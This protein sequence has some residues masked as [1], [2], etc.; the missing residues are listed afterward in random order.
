LSTRD[1]N[2]S[3]LGLQGTCFTKDNPSYGVRL[4][5]NICSSY[6]KAKNEN[7][8]NGPKADKFSYQEPFGPFQDSKGTD[9]FPHFD[10]KSPS[11]LFQSNNNDCG[12]AAIANSMAF[13]IHNKDKWFIKSN[14]ST[15]GKSED[16][17]YLLNDTQ[18]GL[19][20]FWKKLTKDAR[21]T[22]YGPS[23]DSKSIF[24]LMRKEYL[25]V[26]DQIAEDISSEST[27]NRLL[28]DQVKQQ[29]IANATIPD[30]HKAASA[31]T[32][33]EDEDDNAAIR[34]DEEK[35]LASA[36][37]ASFYVQPSSTRQDEQDAATAM[38]SLVQTPTMF[39]VSDGS[40][41]VKASPTEEKQHPV[42]Q[43]SRATFCR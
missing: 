34:Q 40:E 5:L 35:Q 9:E 36:L 28:Y 8:G 37:A 10:Y 26:V 25:E 31:A 43:R 30:Q 27:S 38:A 4:F 41:D 1:N 2:D 23:F 12:L 18:Y 39:H 11:I 29:T 22:R 19:K 13:I 15:G 14:M 24:K 3:G 17:R 16:V 32:M 20:P 21:R 7:D 33:Q 6:L 42:K